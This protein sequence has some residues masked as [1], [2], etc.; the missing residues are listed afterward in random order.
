MP[1]IS[2]WKRVGGVIVPQ[3]LR[4]ITG[5]AMVTPHEPGRAE[6]VKQQFQLA[7]LQCAPSYPKPLLT[8]DGNDLVALDFEHFI[9]NFLSSTNMDEVSLLQ[10]KADLDDYLKEDEVAELRRV[11]RALPSV[12]LA[13]YHDLLRNYVKIAK[14]DPDEDEALELSIRNSWK[15]TTTVW[16]HD[17]RV[18]WPSRETFQQNLAQYFAGSAMRLFNHTHHVATTLWRVSMQSQQAS[19]FPK[20]SDVVDAE[21]V[22][23]EAFDPVARALCTVYEIRTADSVIDDKKLFLALEVL[24]RTRKA[25]ASY[26]PEKHE[27]WAGLQKQV[28]SYYKKITELSWNLFTRKISEEDIMTAVMYSLL[29]DFITCKFISRA[30]DAQTLH[31]LVHAPWSYARPFYRQSMHKLAAVIR[32]W[33]FKTPIRRSVYGNGVLPY[34]YGAVFAAI[35]IRRFFS[36]E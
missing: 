18:E 23:N 31:A 33:D 15:S 21:L 16:P 11:L 3:K 14:K 12:C 32:A 2:T 20:R 29:L 24:E 17:I 6:L 13:H 27:T 22:K 5:E 25:V 4:G 9:R 35:K 30:W 36:S 7:L 19:H 1:R 8:R 28:N 26:W 34:S 10:F